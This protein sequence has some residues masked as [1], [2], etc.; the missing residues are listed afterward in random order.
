MVNLLPSF[1]FICSFGS[2]LPLFSLL[3]ISTP[4]LVQTDIHDHMDQVIFVTHAHGHKN[5]LERKGKD[6]LSKA[7]PY[8]SWYF[9]TALI[10]PF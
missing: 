7:H 10:S 1:D 5:E 6:A 3:I 9:D 8:F 4:L 2:N